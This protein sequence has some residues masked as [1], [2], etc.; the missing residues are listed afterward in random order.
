MNLG[1]IAMTWRK[2]SDIR[3]RMAIW[4]RSKAPVTFGNPKI[5]PDKILPA[6][7]MRN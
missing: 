5:E 6:G 2:G 7:L 4:F 1:H 3:R